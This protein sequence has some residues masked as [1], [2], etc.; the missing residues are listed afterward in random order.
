MM[1]Q[2][3]MNSI[4]MNKSPLDLSIQIKV[5]QPNGHLYLKYVNRKRL[6]L[7]LFSNELLVSQQWMI[8]FF[9]SIILIGYF[10]LKRNRK[11]EKIPSSNSTT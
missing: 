8:I 9:V 4:L 6:I 10:Y 2:L 11:E 1:S 7:I 3:K 5:I